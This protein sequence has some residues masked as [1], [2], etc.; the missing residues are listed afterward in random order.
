M[1]L[2]K[3]TDELHL[4]AE[5]LLSYG[6]FKE[7]GIIYR[8]EPVIRNPWG[9]PGLKN[10]PEIQYNI[11]H[12]KNCAV[13]VISDQHIVGID[14]E[15]VRPFNPSA[16]SK[17]CSPQEL[18]SIY[19]KNDADREF[20]R[21]WTLKESYIKAVGMGISYPMKSVNFQIGT[22]GEI[23]SHMPGCSFLLMEDI[24]GFVTAVCYKKMREGQ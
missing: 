21:Y 17:V 14:V 11:S 5:E 22:N 3:K 4:L 19:S 13:C 20:F 2:G 10:Y 24:N 18:K 8:D 15:K 16:A 6:L 7:K 12:S 1:P 23:L 9:K